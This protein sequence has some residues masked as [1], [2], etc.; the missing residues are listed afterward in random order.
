MTLIYAPSGREIE[1]GKNSYESGRNLQHCVAATQIMNE[2]LM[3]E[4]EVLA[5]G[6][7]NS[8]IQP[9]PVIFTLSDANIAYRSSEPRILARDDLNLAQDVANSQLDEIEPGSRRPSYIDLDSRKE[10]REDEGA[11]KPPFVLNDGSGL[12]SYRA[13]QLLDQFGRNELPEKKRARILIFLEQLYQPMSLMLWAAIIILAAIEQY[14]DLAIL[15]F[16]LLANASI[17]YYEMTKSADAIA[18]LKAT[19]QPSAIVKRD[20]AWADINAAVVVPGD[21]VKLSMG[22]ACPADCR[23]HTTNLAGME[24][25]QSALTGESKTVH[26]FFNDSIKMGTTVVKGE[27]EA[28]VEFTGS[29]TYFGKTAALLKRPPT[30]SNVQRF[31]ISVVIILTCLSLVM[32]I[33][34]FLWLL[35]YEEVEVVDALRFTV[36][37]LVASIP[38]AIE[39]VTTTTLALGSKEL[40]K[41]GAITARLAAI[42]DLA[43]MSILCSDKTGTLTTNHMVLMGA[44]DGG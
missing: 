27:C 37:L 10:K 31:I 22:C 26:L 19:L 4:E 44:D 25:D 20:G 13:E 39:I 23:L 38:L 24:V 43:G 7:E 34:A 28:T 42:E 33:I 17:A 29:Y 30:L 8:T 16:I 3:E 41:H 21:L 6:D 5:D 35:L 14:I 18:A 36:V 11:P 12:S 2:M 32:V 1:E 15:L 9:V 40:S